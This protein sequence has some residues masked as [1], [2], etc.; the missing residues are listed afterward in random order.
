MAG[1]YT[2]PRV[3]HPAMSGT[4]AA[5][6]AR[7]APRWSAESGT[8]NEMSRARMA[9]TAPLTVATVTAGSVAC[10]SGTA[11]T[12]P[13]VEG[14]TVESV[15]ASSFLTS[16]IAPHYVYLCG[17]FL[18]VLRH[19]WLLIRIIECRH[20]LAPTAIR[21]ALHVVSVPDSASSKN[22]KRD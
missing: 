18:P 2:L 21:L 16:E 15:M 13:G 3:T 4:T 20:E 14:D 6:T 10:G 5:R 11:G 7:M 17:K 9:A 19:G 1:A 12:S 22:D 8:P